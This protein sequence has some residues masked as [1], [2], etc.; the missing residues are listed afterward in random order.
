MFGGRSMN[1][2]HELRKLT[3]P[4]SLIQNCAGALVILLFLLCLE[5]PTACALT[6]ASAAVNYSQSQESEKA[7]LVRIRYKGDIQKENAQ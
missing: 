3:S 7:E 1:D 4:R 2:I 5:S 6:E